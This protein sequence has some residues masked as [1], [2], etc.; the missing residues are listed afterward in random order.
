MYSKC[1]ILQNQMKQG[2]ILLH[3]VVNTGY[4]AKQF[5]EKQIIR[6]YSM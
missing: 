5:R 6:I 4:P 2:Q 1:R 3:I